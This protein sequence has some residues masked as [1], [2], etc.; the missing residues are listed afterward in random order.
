MPGVCVFLIIFCLLEIFPSEFRIEKNK[1]E[2]R[3]VSSPACQSCM[4][5]SVCTR[6]MVII[7]FYL[8][9]MPVLVMLKTFYDLCRMGKVAQ[10]SEPLSDE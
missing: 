5:F 6:I 9:C 8:V 1:T 2:K 7:F 10:T 4:K 3:I